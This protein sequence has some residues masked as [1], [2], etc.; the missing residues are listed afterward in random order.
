MI[1]IS[2]KEYEDCVKALF[3]FC[4]ASCDRCPFHHKYRC[5]ARLMANVLEER[6]NETKSARKRAAASA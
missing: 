3:S 5:R 1:K 2:R 6:M 4:D